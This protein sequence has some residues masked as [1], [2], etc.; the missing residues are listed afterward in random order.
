[1]GQ[2]VAL[3]VRFKRALML[4]QVA[5]ADTLLSGGSSFEELRREGLMSMTVGES[6]Q[7]FQS[8]KPLNLPVS[9]RAIGYL[10][11][12]VSYTLRVGR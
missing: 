11:P 10:K 2:F 8:G 6:K 4:A 9:R 5:E 3:P 7:F 12:Y 1:V